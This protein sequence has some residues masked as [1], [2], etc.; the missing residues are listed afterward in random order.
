MWDMWN[1]GRHQYEPLLKTTQNAESYAAA[2]LE[3]YFLTQ[4]EWTEV[5][6][7]AQLAATFL[8]RF[9]VDLVLSVT[10]TEASTDTKRSRNSDPDIENF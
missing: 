8:V 1:G 10:R 4:C 6:P 5:K 3:F 9:V 2:A 7:R